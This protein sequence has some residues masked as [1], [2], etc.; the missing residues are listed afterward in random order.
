M[1]AAGG[2]TWRGVP[3]RAPFAR[4]RH[5]QRGCGAARLR[6]GGAWLRGNDV[7]NPARPARPGNGDSAAPASSSTSPPP[8]AAARPVPASPRSSGGGRL[9][10]SLVP[11]GS[12]TCGATLPATPSPGASRQGSGLLPP[13]PGRLPR[14]GVGHGLGPEGPPG[15]CTGVTGDRGREGACSCGWK[16]PGLGSGSGRPGPGLPDAVDSGTAPERG[17]RCPGRGLL[18][19]WRPRA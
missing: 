19:R 8:P 11:G 7:A 16:A 17:D 6:G 4:L 9:A 2:G 3:P 10:G 14:A 12:G 5:Q 15:P 13:D 18:G 1:P